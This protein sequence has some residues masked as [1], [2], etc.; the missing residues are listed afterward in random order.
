MQ[1]FQ[2]LLILVHGSVKGWEVPCSHRSTCLVSYLE[3]FLKVLTF[4][5][6]AQTMNAS[7]GRIPSSKFEFTS[8]LKSII[9]L[10]SKVLKKKGLQEAKG[11]QNLTVKAHGRT[12]GERTKLSVN[13]AS[14]FKSS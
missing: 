12:D 7:T 11:S 8:S 3:A 10:S 1:G 4:L 14:R 6:V 2:A 13:A 9:S 5:P